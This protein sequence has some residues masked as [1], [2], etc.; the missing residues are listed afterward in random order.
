MA[1][2][3]AGWWQWRRRQPKQRSTRMKLGRLPRG[4][5]PAAMA[6]LAS[7]VLAPS[8]ASAA[9]TAPPSYATL[10]SAEPLY[11]PGTSSLPVV[12]LHVPFV[13]GDT[14]NLALSD[15]AAS[16]AL[17]DTTVKPMSGD[18]I[19]G[20]TCAGYDAKACKDPFRPEASAGHGPNPDAAHSEQAA[21]W[22]GKDG[23]AP[24]SIHALTDCPGNCGPQVVHSLAD[25][26]GPAGSIP[27]YVSIG[28]SSAG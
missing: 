8:T 25:G 28:G 7:L 3:A 23:K 19:V 24:G 16:L 1:I 9:P 17:P 27:G 20:L 12:D 4:V 13:N 15:S 2:N 26:A 21:S 11:W 5:G 10:A 22:T 18:A 14:N 6:A